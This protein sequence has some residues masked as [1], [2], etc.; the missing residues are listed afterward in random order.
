MHKRRRREQHA[1][2]TKLQ[3]GYQKVAKLK[4]KDDEGATLRQDK[5]EDE[6]E[7]HESENQVMGSVTQCKIQIHCHTTQLSW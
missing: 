2:R 7:S 4:N 3:Q 1:R 6:K 5:A